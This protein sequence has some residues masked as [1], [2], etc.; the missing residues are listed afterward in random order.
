MQASHRISPRIPLPTLEED[1]TGAIRMPAM[2]CGLWVRIPLSSSAMSLSVSACSLPNFVRSAHTMVA[3]GR[4]A[5]SHWHIAGLGFR[6][7]ER[8]GLIL[9]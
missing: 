5:F 2:F 7:F 6:G 4:E 3:A 1:S 9:V 8:D